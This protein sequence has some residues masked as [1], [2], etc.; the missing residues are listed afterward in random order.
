MVSYCWIVLYHIVW[1]CVV[2]DG[3]ISLDCPVSY[4]LYRIVGSYRGMILYC[5]VVL[6]HIVASYFPC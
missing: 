5:F 4:Q 2:V 3:I 1:Y 6:H